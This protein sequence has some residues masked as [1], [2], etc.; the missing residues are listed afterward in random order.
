[1]TL[2]EWLI[3]DEGSVV[4]GTPWGFLYVCEGCNRGAEHE[5]QILSVMLRFLNGKIAFGEHDNFVLG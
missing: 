5:A 1:V 2:K 3:E 4:D